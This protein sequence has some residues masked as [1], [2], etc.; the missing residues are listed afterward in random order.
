MN[1]D[2]RGIEYQGSAA[3][4]LWHKSALGRIISEN[5]IYLTNVEMLFCH[6]HRNIELPYENWLRDII[7]LNPS[8]IEEYT[9]LETLRKPG[10]KI[11]LSDNLKELKFHEDEESWGL[12]WP[13]E[14]HPRDAPPI[15]EVRWFH[16]S[17]R[18]DIINLF[19][20]CKRVSIKQR[21]AEVLIVDDELAVVTYRIQLMNPEGTIEVPTRSDYDTI[22]SY[23][24]LL[25]SNGNIF[26]QHEGDWRWENIGIPYNGGRI[27]DQD[28][29]M[30]ISN[31]IDKNNNNQNNTA[32]IKL[33]LIDRG[34]NPRPGFKYGSKWRCY[35][36]PMGEN[37]A[38][39]LVVNPNDGPVNWEEACLASRLAAGVNKIW[40]FPIK[41]KSWEY[42]SI[43]RPPPNSRWNN[44]IKR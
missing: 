17:H 44:P 43:T 20:W 2:K 40:L 26:I 36:S 38:P 12:R 30:I 11:I 31:D 37:H 1:A 33:D 41:G 10:N 19:H 7:S 21:I 25:L 18:L 14:N 27:I 5:N 39:W 9:I 16:A 22:S 23:N 32:S 6:E 8:I 24:K 28:M 4:R 34:L 15:S 29:S 3:N 42:I 35:D 13:S